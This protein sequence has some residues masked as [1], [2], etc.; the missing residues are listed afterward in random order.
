MAKD[1]I[2][3]SHDKDATAVPINR[4]MHKQDVIPPHTPEYYSSIKKNETLPFVTI[5]MDLE[6]I[7]LE[8]N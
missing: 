4:W 8:A 5:W 1:I 7:M 6:G 3:N 2:S